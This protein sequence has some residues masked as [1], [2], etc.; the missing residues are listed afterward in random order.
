MTARDLIARALRSIGVLAQG[1]TPTSAESQDA[2]LVL[3]DMISTW[4]TLRQTLYTI[5]RAVFDLLSGTQDY[6]LGVWEATAT[7]PQPTVASH[8]TAGTTTY[9][10]QVVATMAT[11]EV[12]AAGAIGATVLGNA[13]L[14]ALNHSAVTWTALPGA[15]SYAVYRTLGGPTTGLIAS[16]LTSPLLDDTGLAGD[17]STAPLSA[18]GPPSHWE[19]VRPVWVEGASVLLLTSAPYPLELPLGRL[20]VEEWQQTRIKAVP[21]TIP[22]QIYINEGWPYTTCSLWPVPSDGN[23][24]VALYLPVAVTGFS[25]LTTEYTFPPGYADALRYQLAVRLAPEYGRVIDP[26]IAQLASDSLAAIKRANWEPIEMQVDP[27]LAPINER[28]LFNW[29]TG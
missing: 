2:L 1:E 15:A 8:G 24:D 11:G 9:Q 17:G 28:R 29:I 13:T 26:Q 7:S 14:T 19:H 20:T 5:E 3:Q 23:V 16:G 4:G 10:Y 6:T 27:A 21:S 18:V 25:D 22:R 12:L